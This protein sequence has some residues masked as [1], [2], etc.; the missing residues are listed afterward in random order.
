[1]TLKAVIFDFDGT[2]VDSNDVHAT[3][4]HRALERAGHHA[5]YARVRAHMGMGGDQLIAQLLGPE[6]EERE[7]EELRQ[8][9]DHELQALLDDPAL[10][11]RVFPG[12]RELLVE[13]RQRGF[14]VAIA[15]SSERDKLERL[16]RAFGAALSK[17]VDELVTA[18]Q[19]EA[20]KPAP[21][22]VCAALAKL[23]LEPEEASMV[24]DTPYDANACRAA[25][26]DCVGVRSGGW[27]NALLHAAGARITYADVA[28]LLRR[29]DEAFS[30][31][32]RARR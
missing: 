13:L 23:Q 6:V 18:S 19:V 5:A 7:G 22:L 31:A 16:E 25:G 12:A 2:L 21:D 17:D 30:V 29:L 1:M 11:R 9:Q 24:G 10:P 4:W 32:P 15:T 20:S 14:R 26:V 28:E 8:R 3:A 27:S